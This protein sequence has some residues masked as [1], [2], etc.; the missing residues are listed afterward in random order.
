M[1]AHLMSG[2]NLY[3]WVTLFLGHPVLLFLKFL[4]I[5]LILNSCIHIDNKTVDD[6]FI[7]S[8]DIVLK[9]AE[10]APDFFYTCYF[11]KDSEEYFMGVEENSSVI[12]VYSLKKSNFLKRM[13]LP[14]KRKLR[15]IFSSNT[16]SIFFSLNNASEIYLLKN[17]LEID[18][19]ISFTDDKLTK[20]NLLNTFGYVIEFLPSQLAPLWVQGNNIY[21]HNLIVPF[22][23]LSKQIPLFVFENNS[24]KIIVNTKTGRFPSS[25]CLQDKTFFPFDNIFSFTVNSD[26]QTV[27]SYGPDNNLYVF[28]DSVLIQSVLCKSEHFVT[29]ETISINDINNSAIIE[30]RFMENTTYS[31]IYYDKYRDIYYRTVKLKAKYLLDEGYI[32]SDNFLYSIMLIDKNFNI[33]A[34]QLFENEK[35]LLNSLMVTKDG[36]MLKKKDDF[37]GNTY[38]S[39]FSPNIKYLEKINI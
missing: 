38:Y 27:C 37:S 22:L 3:N 6:A 36:F 8:K 9:R 20:N 2:N 4:F 29:P 26:L 1:I 33:I 13:K 24:D 39:I 23:N 30:K 15:G 10:N 32:N 17:Y 5:G 35:Y 31:G 14:F 34:E 16:D 21:I 18:T 28:K 19:V 25:L 7:K 12:C 11:E